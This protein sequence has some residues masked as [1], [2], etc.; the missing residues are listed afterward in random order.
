MN[1][2]EIELMITISQLKKISEDRKAYYKI[3]T[4]YR[5]RL[6]YFSIDFC[7]GFVSYCENLNRKFFIKFELCLKCYNFDS[8]MYLNLYNV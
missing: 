5:S 8:H 4:S 6:L 7:D 3:S 2:I 1:A